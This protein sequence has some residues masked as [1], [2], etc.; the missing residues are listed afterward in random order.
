MYLKSGIKIIILSLFIFLLGGLFTVTQAASNQLTLPQIYTSSAFDVTF[1]SASVRGRIRPGGIAPTTYW[2]E[3][4]V[5]KALG[6]TTQKV[7]DPR[8]D[9]F[10]FT[11]TLTNLNPETRYYFR[12]VGENQF[13]RDAGNITSFSTRKFN[14]K[15]NFSRNRG[16][17]QCNDDFDNDGDGL[18]DLRD[19]GCENSADNS[20][21]TNFG[22]VD[23]RPTYPPPA[24]IT[25]PAAVL[26]ATTAVLGG[27]SFVNTSTATDVWFEWGDSPTALNNTTRR[28]RNGF[29]PTF[30][31]SDTLYVLRPN[32]IYYYRAVANNIYGIAKGDIQTFTTAVFVPPAV[33]QSTKKRTVNKSATPSPII[34]PIQADKKEVAIIKEVKNRS[35]P[36]GTATAVSAR[37]GDVIDFNI[38]V[39][40]TGTAPLT[41]LVVKDSV[42]TALE[43]LNSSRGSLYSNADNGITWII[44]SLQPN[45]NVNLSFSARTKKLTSNAL[46]STQASVRENSRKIESNK[47]LVILN[48][49]TAAPAVAEKNTESNRDKEVATAFTALGEM[50]YRQ[51]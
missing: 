26:N 16:R 8:L 21:R 13:G 29:L 39:K 17:T 4:G 24:V 48:A 2:I 25:K 33:N 37:G 42:P 46:I 40:N 20:E 31:F 50:F 32:V 43:F 1:N 19:P 34:P 9:S 23:P 10:T 3:W 12:A 51:P 35:L 6:R 41:D 47:A 49:P 44:S 28:Q 7:S 5:T 18:I 27:Q 15:I 30:D 36:N 38:A 11:Q 45:E 14:D 22:F